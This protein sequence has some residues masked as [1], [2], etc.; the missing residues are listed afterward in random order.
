[1]R[2]PWRAFSVGVFAAALTN[3]D[4]S[5]ILIGVPSIQVAL[6]A[7]ATQVQL[8]IAGYALAYGLTLVPSGRI[9]DV[10]S[11]RTVFLV[12]L[13][14][15][16]AAS[17]TCALAP[18]IEVLI[19]GRLIQ[20]LA[21][22]V[23]MPQ[24]LGLGQL[25]FQGRERARALGTLATVMAMAATAGPAVGG[26]LLGV[27]GGPEGWRLLFWLNVP[28]GLVVLVMAWRV[29]PR[30]PHAEEIPRLDVIG[31]VL[32][33]LATFGVMAPFLLATT[34]SALVWLWLVLAAS[35]LAL[36]ILWERRLTRLRQEPVVDFGLLRIPTFRNGMVVLAFYY[37]GMPSL[38]QMT[39]IY[40]QEVLGA[41]PL[42]AGLLLVPF[43]LMAGATAW[44][45]SRMVHRGGG[46]IVVVGLTI[47]LVGCGA[48]IL[49]SFLPAD[50]QVVAIAIALLGAGVGAGGVM[51]IN[52]IIMLS[53]IDPVVGG[54][55]GSL[56]QVGQRVGNAIGLSLVSGV[57]YSAAASSAVAGV[58]YRLAAIATISLLAVALV[59]SIFNRR[60]RGES[61]L[62]PAVPPE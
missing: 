27:A 13:T 52:Q 25:L 1:M 57:Y 61:D 44:F 12:G 16:T 31:I 6:D 2:T 3:L 28:L 14:A 51:S 47:A 29:L 34:G 8:L 23:I 50:R 20:G 17:V 24:V 53:K 7:D 36:F 56:G 18:T 59:F 48:A 5:K 33:G 21:A 37:A 9:G 55:A 49:A 39:A 60:S 26:L 19:V 4:I 45:G 30:Q 35:V 58:P 54:V 46:R 11:R 40:S 62:V 41:S 32:L 43:S 15:F 42:V 22:G 10:R 38:I